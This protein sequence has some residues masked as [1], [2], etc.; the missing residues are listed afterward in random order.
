MTR[1]HHH[2]PP[3]EMARERYIFVPT[4]APRDDPSSIPNAELNTF[5]QVLIKHF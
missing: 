2:N 3:V 1:Y 5:K 4:F